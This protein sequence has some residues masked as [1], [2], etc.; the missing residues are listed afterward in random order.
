MQKEFFYREEDISFAPWSYHML[1]LLSNSDTVEWINRTTTSKKYRA[2]HHY[3]I[4]PDFSRNTL[5]QSYPGIIHSFVAP[6][7]ISLVKDLCEKNDLELQYLIKMFAVGTYHVPGDKHG[8]IHTDHENV[9]WDYYHFILYLTDFTEG[10]TYIYDDDKQNVIMVIK[11]KKHRAVIFD[12]C[13]HAQGHCG[14]NDH[15]VVIAGTFIANKKTNSAAK[16]IY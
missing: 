3:I 13:Y 10:Y 2:N 12:R 8:D 14:V 15:R 9:E 1:E 4:K 11:P 6:Y 5:Q 7:F 16:P